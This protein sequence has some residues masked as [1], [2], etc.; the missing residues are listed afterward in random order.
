VATGLA[1]LFRVQEGEQYDLPAQA[2]QGD[3]PAVLVGEG[4][5]RSGIVQRGA[6]PVDGL[7][8]LTPLAWAEGSG[9]LREPRLLEEQGGRR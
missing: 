7:R 5:R 2:G 4:E 9:L 6:V 1:D 8:L 3:R